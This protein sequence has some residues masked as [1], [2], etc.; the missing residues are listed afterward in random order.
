[1][2][3]FTQ[4]RLDEWFPT[5]VRYLGLLLLIVL[6]LAEVFFG[7]S[8]YPG[9]YAAAAGMILYKSV[10]RARKALA[11]EAAQPDDEMDGERWSHLP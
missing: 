2:A 5:L 8:D 7:I 3:R 6:V 11:Q 10:D 9:A 4:Q 1:V